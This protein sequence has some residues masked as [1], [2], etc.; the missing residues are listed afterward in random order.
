MSFDTPEDNGAFRTEHDF[1][2][3]LLSDVDK[4]V[5]T[6]YDVL[7]APDDPFSDYPERVS[8]LIDTDGVIRRSYAVSDPPGHA[9]EVLVDLAAEQQ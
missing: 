9:A 1:P 5:G 4:A 6:A 3:P 7:R 8:Y 2:F